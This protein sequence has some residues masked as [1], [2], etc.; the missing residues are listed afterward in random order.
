M[1][2]VDKNVDEGAENRGMVRSNPYPPSFRRIAARI[3]DPAMGASTC[4]LGSHRWNPYIGIFIMKAIK[5]RVH[6]KDVRDRGREV[7][8]FLSDM[9]GRIV[10]FLY[11]NM[12][13]IAMRSGREPA[14]V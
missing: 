5:H 11:L 7:M 2:G 3:I 13:M 10:V 8:V 12:V 6:H 9:V 1:S 4:A 14:S